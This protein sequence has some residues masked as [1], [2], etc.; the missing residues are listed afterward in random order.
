M[1]EP[2]FHPYAS[3]PTEHAF[4]LVD[5]ASFLEG[6]SRVA[7]AVS[8]VTT[9]GSAGRDGLAVTAMTPV[10]ADMERPMLLTCIR[11][12]SRPAS[13]IERNG[14]FC[15]SVLAEQHAGLSDSFA[16]RHG[17]DKDWFAAER[18]SRLRTAAPALDGALVNFDCDIAGISRMGTHL[19]IFGAVQAVRTAPGQPLLHANRAY[20]RLSTF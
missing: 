18:W 17:H 12:T 3:E 4:P 13:V 2:M 5:R 9:D 11:A 15:V 10:S 20:G 16:G 7:M 6:M 1:S 19:V 14:V 8:I